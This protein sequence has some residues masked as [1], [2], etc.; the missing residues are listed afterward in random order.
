MT[1]VWKGFKTITG[2]CIENFDDTVDARCQ[3]VAVR[4]EDN[5]IQA[6]VIVAELEEARA[7]GYVPD[8]YPSP[9]SAPGQSA[10]F[11]EGDDVIAGGQGGVLKGDS[12]DDVLIGN[13]SNATPASS[14]K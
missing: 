6:V 9:C 13:G 8:I 3:E 12:G 2:A 11:Y 4:G 14:G 10:V 1:H 7:V 5:G